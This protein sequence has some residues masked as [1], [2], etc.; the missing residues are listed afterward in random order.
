MA[1]HE[2]VTE[3]IARDSGVVERAVRRQLAGL[4]TAQGPWLASKQSSD[5][6]KAHKPVLSLRSFARVINH[7]Q[8]TPGDGVCA[9]EKEASS[10][11][12]GGKAV[13]SLP[14]VSCEA[15]GEGVRGLA[16]AEEPLP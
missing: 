13:T 8:C 7:V 9:P 10:P 11:L 4:G 14:C 16:G 2:N 1:S 12:A 6:V 15:A 5:C 3:G